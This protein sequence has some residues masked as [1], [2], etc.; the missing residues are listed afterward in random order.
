MLKG[1]RLNNVTYRYGPTFNLQLDLAIP[2]HSVTVV[3]GDNGAGKTTL[4]NLLTGVLA[5]QSGSI[6][7]SPKQPDIGYIFQNPDDQIIQVTVEK[8]LAFNL[9]NKGFPVDNIAEKV[10]HSLQE[11]KF[12]GRESQSPT[13]LSGGERQRLALASTLI[14]DPDLLIL[15]E[16]TSYLDY[17]QREKLYIKI[18]QLINKGNTIIWVTHEIDEMVMADQIVELKAGQVNFYG[19]PEAYLNRFSKTLNIPESYLQ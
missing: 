11:Y 15:D 16:P 6:N 13:T 14:S 5:P 17:K 10:M 19:P 3:T 4:L 9:E 2:F 7:F 1:I 12:I 18:Q 8:E